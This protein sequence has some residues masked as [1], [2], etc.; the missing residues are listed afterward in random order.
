MAD[1]NTPYPLKDN[2][3]VKTIA[4]YMKIKYIGDRGICPCPFCKDKGNNFVI[5]EKEEKFRCFSCGESGDK[6]DFV[7]KFKHITK[8]DA[9]KELG[10]KI[11]KNP[12]D[13]KIK[14]ELYKIN[15]E[16][17]K[18]FNTLLKNNKQASKYL[19]DRELDKKTVN[20]FGLG[21][22]GTQKNDLYLHLK[23]MGFSNDMLI[24]SGLI[25]KSKYGKYYDKFVNRIM[26]PI[27]DTKNNLVGFG[28]RVLDDSKPKYLNSPASE[29]FDKSMTLYGYNLASK[30][31]FDGMLICE[32]YM[33]VI[34]LHKNGFDC[35]T[36]SLGTAFN[37]EHA[38]MLKRIKDKV[39]VCFDGDEAGTKAKLKAIPKL[40]FSDLDVVIINTSPYKDPDDFI[41]SLGKEEF[42]KRM[43]D[44]ENSYHFEIRIIR[45][46]S[47]N[48][49]DFK[50]EVAKLMLKSTEIE[51][52][53]YKDAYYQIISEIPFEEQL[54]ETQEAD[55]V[56]PITNDMIY[57]VEDNYVEENQNK[58][59][60]LLQMLDDYDIDIR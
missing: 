42:S 58:D 5:S 23:R 9:Y 30:T 37:Q 26:F 29:I 47:E 6:I 38:E 25:G 10:I 44:A 45:E 7:A 8:E 51:I 35:A 55:L 11:E 49:D 48:L 14:E 36:A 17:G 21:Y 19:S 13:E 56:I 39:Y 18:Y 3:I 1:K 54:S 31:Q 46:N 24:K 34:A 40:R 53:N 60:S 32:G 27:F 4:N 12:V 28:G 43:E 41:K 20:H 52:N 33:D 22:S 59:D 15:N 2:G 57:G 16:A 50:K